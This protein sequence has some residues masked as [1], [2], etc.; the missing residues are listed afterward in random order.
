MDH[1][2]ISGAFTGKPLP[3]S[4]FS[5]NAAQAD[6]T[7]DKG[8]KAGSLKQYVYQ[9]IIESL[10]SGGFS[11]DTILTERQIVAHYG[12]SKAPVREALIQLCYEDVLRSI[13]RCGY[14]IVPITAKR[15]R[16]LTDLRLILEPASLPAVLEN[17]TEEKIQGFKDAC[18]N[19]LEGGTLWATWS[20]N[21]RFHIQLNLCAQNVQVTNVLER[22]LISCA[23]AY[24]QTFQQH[25]Q[26]VGTSQESFHTQIISALERNELYTAQNC[27]RQDILEMMRQL[28]P[29]HS[30]L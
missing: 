26:V 12:V 27:L 19:D 21:I 20:K 2:W 18:N 17:L 28:L 29:S 22:T 23:L 15:I 9:Q 16:D 3:P 10:C 6:T 8:K 11:Q 5:K 14:Q 1:Q 24:A 13:P 7:V 4:G 25:G 30:A